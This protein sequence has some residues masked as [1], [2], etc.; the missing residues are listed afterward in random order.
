MRKDTSDKVHAVALGSRADQTACGKPLYAHS[1]TRTSSD[2][3]RV[4]CDRCL[5]YLKKVQRSPNR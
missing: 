4:D 2:P 5:A 1:A 3:S